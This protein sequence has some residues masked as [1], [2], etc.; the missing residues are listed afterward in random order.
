[1]V[2]VEIM[3]NVVKFDSLAGVRVHPAAELFP[4]MRG[5][6][7]TDLVNNIKDNGLREPIVFTPDGQLLDGRNR[8][9]ACKKIRN[10]EPLTR[11]E[12][13]EP[14]AY[15]ISVNLH[16]RHLSDNQRALIAGRIAAR[17]HGQRGEG[18][19]PK[20][21]SS[22]DGS[23]RSKDLPPTQRQAA[24]LF[25]VSETAV[26]RGRAVVQHGVRSL[27]K[28]VDDDVV[29]LY[30]ASRVAAEMEPDQQEQWV[31]DVVAGTTSP[32]YRAAPDPQP[33]DVEVPKGRNN[34]SPN[35][36]RYVSALAVERVINVLDGLDIAI[37]TAADGLDPSITSEEASQ[38]MRGLSKGAGAHR[39]LLALLKQRTEEST[40]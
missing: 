4:L 31:H 1:M 14:W 9:R 37:D 10:E 27:Q 33:I 32:Q 34:K 8:Y 6:E 15:V 25:K 20:K 28:L 30:T 13:S 38:L 36:H 22:I 26:Y 7:F 23:S 21:E 16:R 29:T 12:Y 40:G 3:N 35:R 18:R 5:Q 17:N 39:R 24:A 19:A 11:V 2:A